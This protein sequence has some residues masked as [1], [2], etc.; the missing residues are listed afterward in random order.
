MADAFTGAVEKVGSLVEGVAKLGAA[1]GVATVTYGVMDLNRELENANLSIAAMMNASGIS[2]GMT[3]ALR[4]SSVLIEKMR[5]DSAVLPGEFEDLLRIFQTSASVGFSSGMSS[6][7]L[8]AMSAKVMASAQLEGI[9]SRIA[10]RQFTLLLSGHA[11][12]LNTLAIRTAGILGPGGSKEFN[13]LSTEDRIKRLKDAFDRMG[14]AI[15]AGNKS[16]EALVGTMKTDWKTFLSEATLPLFARIKDAFAYV[17]DWFTANKGYILVLADQIGYALTSAFNWGVDAIREWYPAVKS[18]ALD[19]YREIR[20]IWDDIEP[21]V[22]RVAESIKTSLGNGQA[23]QTLK[24]IASLYG[25]AKF[26]SGAMGIMPSGSSMISLMSLGA[27]GGGAGGAGMGA[28]FANLGVASLAAAPAVL[29]LIGTIDNL[30]NTSSRYHDM[31]MKSVSDIGRTVTDSEGTFQK[32]RELLDFGGAAYISSIDEAIKAQDKFLGL[33]E[34]LASIIG[35]IAQ[36]SAAPAIDFFS[37]A[38]GTVT[39]RD[40]HDDVNKFMRNTFGEVGRKAFDDRDVAPHGKMELDTK[41]TDVNDRSVHKLGAG[42]GAGIHINKVEI[43]VSSNE[44]P[45]RIARLT[46]AEIANIARNPKVSKSV[47][48]FSRIGP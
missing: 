4:G 25:I 16:M 15:E 29:G 12:A 1:A 48:N 28:A 18:F 24:N 33:L 8:E 6:N 39:H 46:A 42:G 2:N 5:A 21:V 38:Y 36:Y 44:D 20:Q 11:G 19:A 13:K 9:S 17:S 14:P 3:E 35:T 7:E 30:T 43:T 27:Q 40:F 45:S 31:T 26:G 37:K 47:T 41:I 32:L 34:R 23:L 10:A 22:H